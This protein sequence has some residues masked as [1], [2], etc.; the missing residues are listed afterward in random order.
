MQK[1]KK[2]TGDSWFCI[3]C[4]ETKEEEMIQCMKCHAWIHTRCAGISAAIKKFFCC[5]CR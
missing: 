4:E 3:L 5:N 1:H 2:E